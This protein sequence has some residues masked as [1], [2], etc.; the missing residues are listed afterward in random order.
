[1]YTIETQYD[2]KAMTAMGKALRKT[3]RKK[4]S[5]RSHFLGFFAVVLGVL[6]LL[7]NGFSGIRSIFT[8]LA[9]FVIVLALIFEDSLN[10]YVA[11]KRGLPSMDHVVTT[12]QEENYHSVTKIAEST[13]F[14]ESILRFVRCGEYFVFVFSPNHGQVYDIK[15][16]TGGSADD[17]AAFIEKKTKI[18]LE[19]VK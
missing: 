12:F 15:T 11:Q 10:G 18:T 1:M 2:L 3:I 8:L 9:V 6:L 16:L 13:F 4:H 14:Y 5:K 7:A 19:N 17:F